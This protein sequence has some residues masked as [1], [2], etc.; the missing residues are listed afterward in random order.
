M[1]S[2]ATQHEQEHCVQSKQS[3]QHSFSDKS[4]HYEM[5]VTV[6]YNYYQVKVTNNLQI[7]VKKF[8]KIT[9]I[10][11]NISQLDLRDQGHKISYT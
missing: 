8:G 3:S 1:M 9:G 4:L 7:L 10:D 6:T 2:T 5:Q 11:W